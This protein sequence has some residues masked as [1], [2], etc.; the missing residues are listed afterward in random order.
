M[1]HTAKFIAINALVAALYVVFTMPFG[2]ISTQSGLQF[3][4]AEALTIL[5]ALMPYTIWGLA[6]GCAISNLVSVFG[7]ADVVFGA[8]ITFVA[9]FL[10][11]KIKNPFLAAVPPVVLNAVFLP[12]IWLLAAG[13]AAYWV[14]AGGLLLTQSAVI[15]GLGVPLFFLLK[16]TVVPKIAKIN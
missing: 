6:I 12:L 9:A 5:P 11:S 14:N 10:T 13:D 3:R 15:F 1:K 7:I 2:V 16:K 8:L 4:P